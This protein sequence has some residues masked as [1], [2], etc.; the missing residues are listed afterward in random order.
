MFVV[1]LSTSL[2]THVFPVSRNALCIVGSII[3]LETPTFCTDP[4]EP[5]WSVSPALS[6]QFFSRE[7]RIT[8]EKQERQNH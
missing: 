2:L 3:A 8:V 1:L 4:L 7:N 6:S 5:L